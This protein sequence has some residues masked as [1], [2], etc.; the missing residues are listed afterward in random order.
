M[1]T[2]PVA[3]T[4]L[5][6]L[7]VFLVI[8]KFPIAFSLALSAFASA[9]YMRVPLSAVTQSMVA[10]VNSFS[11]LAIPFFILAGEI[12]SAG[13]IS[14]RIVSLANVL[15]GR[16]RGGLAMVNC[17]ESMF[18]GM[19]SGSAIAD[20]S[21]TGPI[22]IPMMKKQGYPVPFACALSSA[23]ACMALLIP[24]SHNMIIYSS[25]V[26]GVSVGKLFMAGLIPGYVLGVLLMIYCYIISRIKKYPVAGKF[27][28]KESLKIIADSLLG[29]FTVV[30]IIGGVFAGIV[31][32]TESSVLACLWA[33]IIALFVYKQ[34]KIKDVVP[35]LKRTLQ[36]IA[37]V[38]TL[39]A[40][41]GAFGFMMTW[42]RIPDIISAG[43]LS[44][45]SNKYVL[46]LLINLTLLALGCFMDMA[47]LILICAP[48]LL[49]VV[50]SPVIG[51]DPVHFGIVMIYNLGVG[52][53]TPPVGTTLFI[54]S[55]IGRVKIEE[56]AKELIPFYCVMFV[57]LLLV[58]F[59]PAISMTVPNLMFG[60]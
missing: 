8:I 31:T 56:T 36:T 5:V 49:P 34:V 3:I 55:A 53:L 17:V 2:D 19:I 9:L 41:A 29:M 32:T 47:P 6:G 14:D 20:V 51:M 27:T 42:L 21:S 16:I 52:L 1:T 40:S 33:I 35:I 22:L 45:S 24:P 59:I 38:M 26:G 54:S 57:G 28:L 37:L 11:L 4:I 48:V 12:M 60:K 18:F 30:I 25:A 13:G 43:L 23:S 10:G 7:F 15:V 58:T 46:L 39:V 50:T 44:V